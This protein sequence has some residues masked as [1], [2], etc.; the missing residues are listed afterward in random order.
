MRRPQQ[1][2]G[3]LKVLDAMVVLPVIGRP[4]RPWTT[5]PS[6]RR[7]RQA[8]GNRG[9]G[10]RFSINTDVRMGHVLMSGFVTATRRGAGRRVAKASRREAGAQF[11]RSDAL[12]SRCP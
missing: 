7:S 2:K 11:H 1:V 4:D 3:A 12:I 5:P 8:D 10:R 6:R 9:P